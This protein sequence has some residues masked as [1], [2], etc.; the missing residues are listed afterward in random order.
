MAARTFLH[1]IWSGLGGES[2][3]ATTVRIAGSGALPSLFRTTDLAAASIAAAGLAISELIA[4]NHGTRPD[5][6]VDRRLASFWFGTTL[7]PQGWQMPPQWDPIAG[8]YAASD[9]WI[10]LHTNAP[11]HRAAAL[12]VLGSP[13][14]RA[15]VAAAVAGWKAEA[16]ETA[17]VANGG[18][19]AAMRS[20]DDWAVHPQGSAVAAEPLLWHTSTGTGA[21]PSW[22][23]PVDRPLQGVRV[24]DLTRILAGPVATRFLAG[25]GAQVLRLDPLDWDEPAAAPEVT[26]GKRCGRIDLRTANGRA[27]F[28]QLLSQAD[29]LIHGYRT[30]AL[31]RLGLDADARSRIRP[32]L[33]DVSLNAYGWTGPWTNR[34]GFDSLLQMST[35]IAHAGMQKTDRER[36]VPL[37]VQALDHATGYIMAAAAIRGLIRQRTSGTGCAVRA[38]LARTAQLL[39]S[40]S[41]A[42]PD[43]ALADE[44]ADDMSD[45]LEATAWGPAHRLKPALHIAGTAMHWDHPAGPLG[46]SPAQ[47]S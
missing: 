33:V 43:A 25:F 30:D 42:D 6:T 23:A 19:A 27:L 18:C 3:Y 24:L 37:P 1:P 15:Q 31:T 44:S 32:G 5:V 20:I 17:V 26:L 41:F 36:P 35:G 46:A 8:D 4:A 28:E 13:A 21:I 34:R 7:R 47:W 29:V 9:G 39:V 2:A 12:A 14:D 38:S 45:G 22:T 10:R 40:R 11:H 16:L